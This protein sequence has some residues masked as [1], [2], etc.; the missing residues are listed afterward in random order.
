MLLSKLHLSEARNL[1]AGLKSMYIVSPTLIGR[2]QD[3]DTETDSM[4]VGVAV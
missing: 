1:W 4:I 2:S 3:F